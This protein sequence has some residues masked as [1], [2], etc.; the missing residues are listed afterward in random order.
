VE[1]VAVDDKVVV[2]EA[3]TGMEIPDGL[4]QYEHHSRDEKHVLD[5]DAVT[6]LAGRAR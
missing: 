5:E 6:A 2:A 3:E 4:G 1:V